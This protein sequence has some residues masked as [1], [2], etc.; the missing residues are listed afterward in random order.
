MPSP[1]KFKAN[2]FSIADFNTRY[3]NDE[4]ILKEIFTK[5]FG[6]LDDFNK[7]YPVSERK[8]FAHSETGKQIHP[9]AGTIFH[10]SAT[11]LK[12]WYFAIFL[13]TTSKNG[14]SAKE[15]ERQLGVTYK[16]AYRMGQQIRKL[17]DETGSDQLK[18]TVEMDEAYLGGK[19]G[20]KHQSKRVGHKATQGKTAVMGAVER[21]GNVK[22]RVVDNTTIKTVMPFVRGQI[23]IDT[24][25]VTDDYNTYN[26]ICFAGYKHESVNHSQKEY[27]RDTWHTNTIEGFWS[28]LKRSIDGTYHM[29][30]PQKLQQYVNEF[31]WRYNRRDYK[32][33]L[34]N[35]AVGRV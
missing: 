30:S 28:Q 17:F 16:T 33:C 27:V 34:F 13:F 15:L 25:L 8:C 29:V 14:V 11:P 12:L 6:H 3:P 23:A 35:V 7:Y 2:R 20:N 9:L 32:G 31:S 21:G 4:V 22:A 5:R 19:E 26:D 10:K 18:G 24:Q 1:K